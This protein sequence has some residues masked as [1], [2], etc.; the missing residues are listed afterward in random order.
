MGTPSLPPLI[1]ALETS[2][3][4]GG[5]ALYRERLLG[6]ILL[7]GSITYSRRLLPAVEFLLRH[8]DLRL[9][10]VDILAVSIGPGSFTGLRIGAAT[11]KGLSL[12]LGKPV[13]AVDTLA[14]L[15]ALVPASPYPVCPVL[16]ARRGEIFAALYRTEGDEPRV[17]LPPGLYSPEALCAHLSGPTLFVGEGL[18]VYGDFFR[19]RLGGNF[20]QAPGHLREG[21]AS[22]VAWLASRKALRGEFCDPARLVPFYLRATE[23]ERNRGWR[24]A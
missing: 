19:E 11:V 3:E 12:A 16:D 17:L 20:R 9:E 18:R 10:E 21:R 2:G 8:L 13:V 6:E 24:R 5:V 22:A 4:T 15:A 1:L 7:S 23:A 14:A